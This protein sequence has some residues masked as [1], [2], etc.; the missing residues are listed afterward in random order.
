MMS[1]IHALPTNTVSHRYAWHSAKKN[2]LAMKFLTAQ[3]EANWTEYALDFDVFG[4]TFLDNKKQHDSFSG[5][6]KDML[7][8][9]H[10]PSFQK[11]NKKKHTETATALDASLCCTFKILK[12]PH[13]GLNLQHLPPFFE[14]T[15]H[16]PSTATLN[17][18][19]LLLH[20]LRGDTGLQTTS[21]NFSSN[22]CQ[23]C[24]PSCFF[25]TVFKKYAVTFRVTQLAPKVETVRHFWRNSRHSSVSH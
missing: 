21:F 10:N 17:C 9:L 7:H 5:L 23:T 16:T 12:Q 11:N 25:P 24:Q 1:T 15:F 14:N 22:L 6:Q 3:E 18:E 20:I 13:F 4:K 2:C 19:S 8:K